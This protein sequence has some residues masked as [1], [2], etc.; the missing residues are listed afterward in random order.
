MANEDSLII[1][2]KYESIPQVFRDSVKNMITESIAKINAHSATYK[3]AGNLTVIVHETNVLFDELYKSFVYKKSVNDFQKVSSNL[4]QNIK[5]VYSI[6]LNHSDNDKLNCIIELATIK[7]K[8]LTFKSDDDEVDATIVLQSIKKRANTF[9]VDMTSNCRFALNAL[10]STFLRTEQL[11]LNTDVYN[12]KM[13][14]T[15][16]DDELDGIEANCIG[17]YLVDTQEIKLASDIAFML[18]FVSTDNL[19]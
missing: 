14:K 11:V 4:L 8:E 3:H 13:L 2:E 1:K 10:Q 15:L 5:A 9:G 17:R 19:D 6:I 18:L 12:A 16:D 7:C